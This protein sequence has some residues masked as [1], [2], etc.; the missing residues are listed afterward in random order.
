[1]GAATHHRVVPDRYRFARSL[2]VRNRLAAPPPGAVGAF[3]LRHQGAATTTSTRKN[4]ELHQH[5][6]GDVDDAVI[7]TM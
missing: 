3:A 4:R 5:T 2:R 1:M 6:N 7:P